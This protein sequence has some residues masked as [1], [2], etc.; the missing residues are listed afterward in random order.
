MFVARTCYWL[1]LEG[2]ITTTSA[3]ALSAG[4]NIKMYAV[5]GPSPTG[6]TDAIVV[7]GS[8]QYDQLMQIGWKCFLPLS[9]GY[10]IF[11]VGILISLNWLPN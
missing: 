2:P 10:L 8:G 3:G 4:R 11:T 1:Q 5:R 9:L 7:S 6:G